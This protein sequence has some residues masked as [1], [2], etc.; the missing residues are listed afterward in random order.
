VGERCANFP[1]SVERIYAYSHIEQ[2]E[3]GTTAG[4]PPAY[5]PASGELEVKNLSAKYS[6]DGDKVLH[7]LFF[8]VKSG[9]RIGIGAAVFR[10]SF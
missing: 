2:E 6:L 5:W 4:Q 9:E 8:H 1:S 3:A 7:N 10:P